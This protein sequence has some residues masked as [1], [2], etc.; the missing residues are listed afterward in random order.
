MG[1]EVL[2]WYFVVL[3]EVVE[4]VGGFVVGG[5]VLVVVDFD[6]WIVV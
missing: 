4:E 6:Y 2:Y 3:V 5:I 1:Y